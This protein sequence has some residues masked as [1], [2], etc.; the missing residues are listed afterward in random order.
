M[1][2]LDEEAPKEKVDDQPV[3]RENSPLEATFRKVTAR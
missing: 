2:H 3:Y 1:I